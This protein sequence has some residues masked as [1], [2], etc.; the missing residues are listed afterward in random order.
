MF[1][2]SF[3]E[4]LLISIIALL[5]FKP[6]QL[7]HIAT[8]I[9]KWLKWWQQYWHNIKS[10]AAQHAEIRQLIQAKTDLLNS[11]RQCKNGLSNSYFELLHRADA[12]PSTTIAS[13]SSSS[14]AAA[15]AAA[16]L[17][18]NIMHSLLDTQNTPATSQPELD[19]LK[20]PE[21]FD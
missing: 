5:V 9:G 11:Y 20:Q 19:F 13:S 4:I 12:S 16:N 8:K 14:S 6:R 1:N 3:S 10:E 18:H 7:P 17:H 21:L 15:A 2:I